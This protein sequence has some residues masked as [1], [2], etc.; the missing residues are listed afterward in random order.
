MY[1]RTG[2]QTCRLVCLYCCRGLCDEGQT[3]NNVFKNRQTVK[4]TIRDSLV[5]NKAVRLKDSHIVRQTET[6]RSADRHRHNIT[7]DIVAQNSA[8]DD[9]A[10]G[11]EQ[12]LQ[13][14]WK[15]R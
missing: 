6:E 1:S 3:D 14:S 2:K 12:P 5:R 4:R 11:R 13:V 10:A 15:D 9:V 7:C 8:G